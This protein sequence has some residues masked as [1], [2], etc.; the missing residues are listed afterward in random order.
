MADETKL[1]DY[2]KRAIAD[3]R[4]A[5]R[6]L[7]ETE[8]KQHEP[9]AIVG[10]ACRYPGGVTSPEDLWRLVADGVDAVGDFPAGRGWDLEGLYDP[11][12][13]HTGTSYARHGGFLYEA[14]EFDPGFFGMSPREALA[15]DPQQRLLLQTAW[16]TFERA[17]I[18]PGT[19]RG[20]STGVFTGVMYSDYGSR[21]LLPPDGFEGYLFSGSAGSIAA[22]RL[23]YTFGLEGPAVTVDTACSSSLVALHL[24][25]QALR[26]GECDLALAGGVTVMST[27]VAFIEFSRLRGLAS[28]G[29]CKSFS[30][31]ADGTG[32]SEGVGLLLVERLSDAR[33]NGH[34]VLAV[35]RGS[36]VNQD[37]ASNGLTAPN[38]PSQERVIR[39]ALANAGLRPGD[40]DAVEGHGTGTTLGDPIEANALLATYGQ[41]RSEE[42]PLWLGSLKSNIG[43]AQAAAGVGGI[44]K[45]VEAMRHG[46]LPRTLHA[47]EPSERIDW[48]TGA[49]RLLTEAQ[50]WPEAGAPR[51]AGVSSFGFG[52]TNAH[53][54]VEEAP[55]EETSE[56]PADP[57]RRPSVF[58]WTVSG[59]DEAGLRAQA[60]RLAEFLSGRPDVDPVDVGLS[61]ATTRTALDRRAAVVGATRE[62]LLAGLE[63]LAR[64]ELGPG[65]A[66]GGV[67]R[68][69]RLGF[70]FT[71]QGA[72]RTG[73]G[74]QLYEAFPVFAEAFD[75]VCAALDP[76]LSRPLR[77]VIA[78]G[79]GLDETG[80]TQPAL[81]AFEV[82]LFR[83][84]ES[85]GVRPDF[86]AG[87]SI[88]EV[89]AAHVAGVWPLED[90]C[91]L[92]AARAGLM[93]ELAPGGAMVAVEATEDEVT[94][95]LEG[96]DGVGIAAVNG[97]RAVVVSGSEAVVDEVAAALSERGRRTSRLPVSHAF[98]SPLMEPMLAEFRRVASGLE[99]REPE[100]PLVSALTGD[101]AEP[102]EVMDAEYWVR[103]VREPVRYAEAV[104]TLAEHG[105]TTLLELGPGAVLTAMTAAAV[106][107]PDALLAVPALRA[108]RP[109]PRTL[110]TALGHLHVRGVPVDWAAFHA[111]GGGRRVD[112]PTYAFRRESYWLSP[113]VPATDAAGLGLTPTGHPL[114]GAAVHQA[115]G[116]DT[117]FTGRLSLAAHPWLADH[118]LHGVTVFPGTGL[119]E[120]AV[121]AGRELGCARVEELALSAP[122]VL[123]ERGGVQVQVVVGA[124]NPDGRRKIDVYGRTEADTG[125]EQPWTAHATGWLAVE[126]AE[127]PDAPDV[128]DVHG[129][130]DD[131]TVW[132]P[133]GATELPL[134]DAYA[135]LADDGYHYGPAFQGLGRLWQGAGGDLYA[136]VA[137]P[138]EQRT[139]ATGFALH[140]ALLDAAL[141]PLLP[142]IVDG[143][144]PSRLPFAWS[145]AAI[146]ATGASTLRVRIAA[147]GAEA[148]A[149]T[150]A[151]DTGAPV[152]AVRTLT[153]RPLSRDALR[154][155][156][157]PTSDR[158]LRVDWT[159]LQAAGVPDPGE[160]WAVLGDDSLG[161][162]GARVFRGLADLPQADLPDTVVVPVLPSSDPDADVPAAARAA[163]TGVLGLVR[164]WLGGERFAGARLVVVTRGAVGVGGSAAGTA[165]GSSGEPVGVSDLAH[166]GVWGL[167]RSA[168]TENPG[169]FVLVDVVGEGSEALLSRAVA[170]GEP[171]VV[172]R[173][174]RL[175]VPRLAPVPVPVPVPVSVSV[176]V[177]ERVPD[178]A[179]GV[180]P[181][182]SEGTVLV[183]GA[184]G[185]LGG[186]LARHLVTRRGVRRLLLVSRRGGSAEGAVELREE[187]AG[188]GAEVVFAACD[189]AD[190][191]ALAEVLARVPAESPLR[192]V[193]HAAGV[194]DDVVVSGLS[195]ERLERVLRPKVDAAWN[196]HELTRESDLS[197]FVLYSSLAGLL[198][199]AGQANYAA[200]NAFL[201]G[202]A[203]YRRGLGLP[204][205]SVA[206]GL[207]E[208]SSGASGH[209]GEADLR[210][211]SRLGLRPLASDDAMGLF[212]AVHAVDEP[213]L[214]A[215]GLDTAALRNGDPAPMM[216]G[217]V[218]AARRT[219]RPA[220][221]APAA[222]TPLARR[223]SALTSE[224]RERAVAELVRTHVA[225]VLGH[226]GPHDLDADRP[227]QVM[228]F[229]SLTSVELRNRLGTATGLRLTT[230]L[231]FDHPSPAALTA[232]LLGELSGERAGADVVRAV[233]GVSSEPIA[234]V[235]MACRYPGGVTSPEDLWRLVADGV[236]AV[237]EFPANRGWDL[238][239]LYDPDP[240]HTGTSYA[241][242]GGFLYKADEFD[243]GFFGMS[244]REALA[245]DPQQR[246]LLQTA[247]ETL[248]N[249]GMVPATLRGSRTGVFTGVMY[250]DYGSG[251]GR[252]PQDLEG[253]RAG[254]SAGSVASGRVSYTLGLEGPAVTV[255]TACSSSLV[256][257]HLAAQALRG[258]ECDLALAGGVTVM[259]TPQAFVEFSRQRGLA[260]DGRCKSFSAA[261]DGTG[262]SEGVGLLLV[263]RLSDARRKGHRV[264]AVLRGSAVNQD[265]AS[266]GLT[267]PNGP[268]QERVIRQALANARLQPTDVDAVEAHGTGTT[269][270]DPIEANALLATYGRERSEG[271]PLWLGSL[272][273]NIGHAQAA[274]G[275]GGIIKMVEAMRHGVLPRTLHVDEPSGHVDWDAG[276]VRLLTDARQWPEAESGRPRRAGVSSFGISGTNAHVII[277]QGDHEP[278]PTPTPT[279]IATPT[280][281]TEAG[282]P[283]PVPWLVSGR[284]EA[285]LRAQAG[286]L[287]EFLSG[288]PDVDP[289]D[290]GLSLATTR[291]ALDRRAAVVGAT[292]EELLAGLEGLA[293]GE[294]GPG[295]VAGDVVRGGRLGFVFTGQGAQR[296]G[297]GEQLYE[298]FPVFAEAFDEVCAALDPLLSRPL[299]EVIASGEGLDE[300]GF[301]QPALFAVEVALFRLVES[302]GVRPDVVMGHSIGELVAAYV[303][304]VWSLEDAC[305][306]VAARGRLMQEL[307]PGGAM[308]AVEATEDE[309]TAL[310]EGRAGVGIAAVNGPRAVV[311]SG[312][313]SVVDEVAGV[314]AGQGRRVR[315]LA[316]SHAFHSPLMEPML[317]EFRQAA[318][319]VEYREP[320]IPVVSALT[321]DMAEAG[322]IT[323][324]GYW[325]RHVREPVHYARA[326]HTLAADGVTTFVEIGP[327]A[328]LTALAAGTLDHAPGSDTETDTDTNAGD[329]YLAL[330]LLRRDR[331]EPHTLLQGIGQLH[332]RGV[333]VD[334]AAFYAPTGARRVP[335]PT[336]SFRRES[337]W[338]A[339]EAETAA[340]PVPG[341]TGHPLLGTALSLGGSGDLVFTGLVSASTHPWL[342]QHTVLGH[343]VLSA[344]ALVD[345]AVR[346]GDEVGATVLDEL[347]LTAPLVLPPQ[348]AV[349]LQVRVGAPASDGRCPLTVYAR[350]DTGHD[351]EPWAEYARGHFGAH[352]EDRQDGGPDDGT[353]R[354]LRLPAELA[355]EADRFG[356]HPALLDAALLA[357]PFAAGAGA[358][359]V[360]ATWRGVRLH[361][362]GATALRAV[363]AETGERTVALRLTDDQGRPVA[364][365]DS[366]TYRDVN[367]E[368]FVPAGGG[369]EPLLRVAWV[370]ATVPGAAPPVSWATLGADGYTEPAAIGKAVES[371]T[372][373]DAVLVP[374][375]TAGE[376]D[377]GG[378]LHDGTR[379]AAQ[380]LREWLADERLAGTRLVV[381]TR[382]ATAAPAA[383]GDAGRAASGARS[384]APTALAAA[385]VRGLLR[386]A[387]SEA[388]GRIVLVDAAPAPGRRPDRP[389]AGPHDGVSAHGRGRDT[390]P[391]EPRPG[392]GDRYDAESRA[393]AVHGDGQDAESR[394]AGAHGDLHDAE[395]RTA[396]AHGDLHDQ[397]SR[398]TDVHGVPLALLDALLASGEPEAAVRH[399]R[400]LVPRLTR[401]SGG[402]PSTPSAARAA[403][404]A[405]FTTVPVHAPEPALD[406]GGTVLVT[407]GGALAGLLGRHL[408]A[409]HGARHLLFAGPESGRGQEA[410]V[411]AAELAA[412]GIGVTFADCDPGDRDA[413]AAVLAE[414]PAERPLTAVVHAA[415]LGD[416]G[417]ARD[418]DQDRL[419]DVLRTAADGARHLHELTRDTPLAAFLVL[420]SPAGTVAGPD[421][422]HRAAAGAYLDALAEQRA[423]LGLPSLSLALGPWRHP[424]PA[425]ASQT[426]PFPTAFRPLTAEQVTAAF[427]A[428]LR[429]TVRP[430]EADTDY[431]A[432]A[433][434]VLLAARLDP[435]LTHTAGGVPPLLSNL[436]KPHR[437]VLDRV[438]AGPDPADA[439]GTLARRLEGLDDDARHQVVRDLVRTE[440]AAVLGHGDPA[441]V[442]LR[443]AFQD[444]GLDSITGVELRNRLGAATGMRLPATVV[445]DHPTP[446]ALIAYLLDE[447]A[448]RDAGSTRARPA[449]AT[450]LDWLEAAVTELPEDAPDVD[451]T[452]LG[453][454]LRTILHRLA[455]PG[456]E[457][458]PRSGSEDAASRLAAAS[459]DEIFDFID[460]ELGRGPG[461]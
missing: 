144:T 30:A 166:A 211:L 98:H 388:A 188:L 244:P 437:P 106:E 327:D 315:R 260:P 366:V 429:T 371:G 52:G 100:V 350:P 183:T 172:V 126:A 255:D 87:H 70:V 379:R 210:R 314:L 137:L 443:H 421:Q 461:R 248:E 367:E 82:A 50:E 58:A 83:L 22:G 51:R 279:P 262:W 329:A 278:T 93:Q 236:D 101:L 369:A 31:A 190:R 281:T 357:H 155:A 322:Q 20:S 441:A 132:P 359:A 224:E 21:A 75:E 33:R 272:K 344:A 69:G 382:G 90:A 235:G 56:A 273:S 271:R 451:R 202:L 389:G 23:A 363:L 431:R 138:E 230:T 213:V 92:V 433:P 370:P 339:P 251:P 152:A 104:R 308:A 142:G 361:A 214:A 290:V 62:E 107:N 405:P 352:T 380:L 460:T 146:S 162:P 105:V 111:P 131:L 61:L 335:L 60:G 338:L 189:V 409:R 407:G 411:T 415:P 267:A 310:L 11:D 182:W 201:D 180:V 226:T 148:V 65:V 85:W 79:E 123:P 240:D 140:P 59:R 219:A 430:A 238:E 76:L 17:G 277:E 340:G 412:Q 227:F 448:G 402:R 292:R 164:G 68:G 291:T 458:E 28:D 94:G 18:D 34:Q 215:T 195:G 403:A 57:V 14:D 390:E 362:T 158:L 253:Y 44:I 115:D 414:V 150:V 286:R 426:G 228:G 365:V 436:V 395:S 63:G 302:W 89:A 119:L 36:A 35:L 374:W 288:R 229:D 173:G 231:V 247:W 49:V 12:P 456:A 384:G 147:T 289:V 192:V 196:L 263:E 153:L 199:T 45:M 171:Q 383:T 304:G 246:L 300:T 143:D 73:M 200:G 404:S 130:P 207:W 121:R 206:W 15:T 434:A 237:G 71:G 347:S 368:L 282:M 86:V 181:S 1:R 177:S 66:A 241:R 316:V 120:L 332:S 6:R 447:T 10:M 53:V 78:S 67:V 307:P 257:L 55:A 134:D 356:L 438:E 149:L 444:A 186:V 360:P 416:G 170:S 427:D 392:H 406:S 32:W 393:A 435:T 341:A 337:Y 318:E 445:F 309:V 252:I 38:G 394:T 408:A 455:P 141:H 233:G 419:D 161:L 37:G 280:P 13:D 39:Q 266:N 184:T 265:G 118:A 48:D 261:A 274:A 179:G 440:L 353:V 258:G 376:D 26:G 424:A 275:V 459:A 159:Q 4:D 223:L 420:S 348:G 381:V 303:A 400:L 156:V 81:F 285:G 169:R 331:F 298:A 320:V 343:T 175:W 88:G 24:A 136:E 319:G 377:D 345:T 256:A 77:E 284:D 135:R 269:L 355:H 95:L 116:A 372:P 72:Q 325:V 425:N 454:R 432:E 351:G 16:E 417:S 113:A 270:G 457:E 64:G 243:P 422:A 296:T 342:A 387:Q 254:G 5:R 249:A 446:A 413:L 423:A 212:D 47:E 174:G 373:V 305:R 396:G 29:R 349:H 42:R 397:G 401:I 168:Q 99:Y 198:G 191:D 333:P 222:G 398:T 326:L 129:A 276:A 205:V 317:A 9:I 232:H 301:T 122:L 167:V 127:A 2:L 187:L 386:S 321:G 84:V 221:T 178:S 139:A 109:E 110:L 264:L 346:A 375:E 217:L 442:S 313:A 399:G 54:I 27:P 323:D 358:V 336:Y 225:D 293:R 418:L 117:L 41:G 102:G 452:T 220:G 43:H 234:I 330:P 450:Q 145:D 25:A 295:V 176:P 80:F 133:A 364:T 312:E 165:A 259:S 203:S 194:V 328:I 19:L 453:A 74:E 299:R 294:L 216:R 250:H 283:S 108:T 268:S 391:G 103:H 428:A 185:V 96:R 112:L 125:L 114:L 46:V 297:M 354:E 208:Q 7:Q 218:P 239:G 306:V 154:A 40:V 410:D 242:H 193:V 324:A 439:A 97:P 287:A 449:L 163:V 128:P 209:L 157:G 124:P 385:A 3:A 378:A 160:T 204:A 311:V 8:E 91:R 151:D 245:T 334:W 197:A